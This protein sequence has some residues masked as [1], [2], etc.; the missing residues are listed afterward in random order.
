MENNPSG[1]L[2]NDVKG[3]LP[4]WQYLNGTSLFDKELAIEYARN[5]YA[6]QEIIGALGA[7][8]VKAQANLSDR[9]EQLKKV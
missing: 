9:S 1:D 6:R 8:H 2:K 3:F 7:S 5:L 4:V